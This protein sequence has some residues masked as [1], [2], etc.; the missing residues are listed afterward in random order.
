MGK[1]VILWAF[2]VYGQAPI[3]TKR[4]GDKYFSQAYSCRFHVHKNIII[5]HLFHLGKHE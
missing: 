3:G 2:C 1:L 5:V 4:P